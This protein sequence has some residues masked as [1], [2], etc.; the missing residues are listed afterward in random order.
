MYRDRT[1]LF[2]LTTNHDEYSNRKQR[3]VVSGVDSL[4]SD[5]A[6]TAVRH[7]PTIFI[8]VHFIPARTPA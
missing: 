4:F 5:S 3:L 7:N 1:L 6:V 8:I 2:F